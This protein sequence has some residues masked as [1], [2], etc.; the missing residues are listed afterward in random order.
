MTQRACG[1]LW[2]I[3]G[4]ALMISLPEA[5]GAHAAPPFKDFASYV[6]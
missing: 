2:A 6:S 4:L 3:A 1:F 5:A